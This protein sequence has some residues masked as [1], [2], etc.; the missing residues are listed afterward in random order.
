[1]TF[2]GWLF[3]K[4]LSS[5][6]SCARKGKY[7]GKGNLLKGS[8]EFFFYVQ[9]WNGLDWM[10]FY[11]PSHSSPSMDTSSIPGC[12]KLHPWTLRGIQGQPQLLCASHPFGIPPR[13]VTGYQEA[14]SP[15]NPL[16]EEAIPRQGCSSSTS[17]EAPAVLR[18][19]AQHLNTNPANQQCSLTNIPGAFKLPKAGIASPGRPCLTARDILPH[20]IIKVTIIFIFISKHG[21]WYFLHINYVMY[22][23]A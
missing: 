7:L 16:Q 14:A 18:R 21:L 15:A 17:W 6:C 2:S 19:R 23:K 22:F 5:L 9:S 11:G 12:S 20:G 1:M 10:G 4:E 8:L 3:L 13:R